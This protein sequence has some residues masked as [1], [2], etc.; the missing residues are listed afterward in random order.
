MANTSSSNTNNRNGN[1]TSKT[2]YN[3]NINDIEKEII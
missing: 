3:G 1:Y 2:T